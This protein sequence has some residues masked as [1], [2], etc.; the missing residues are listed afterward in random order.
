M[1]SVQTIE[2]AVQLAHSVGARIT[3]LHVET[4]QGSDLYGDAALLRSMS[5][6]QFSEKFKQRTREILAKAESAC[7]L[8]KVPCEGISLTGKSAHEVI[9]QAA[10]DQGCDLIF[11]A[12]HGRRSA[13]GMMIGSET[14]KTLI[15]AK[16]PVLISSIATNSP[17]LSS[18]NTIIQDEHHA[19]GA[20][21]HRLQLL[22]TNA[23][24]NAALPN[25]AAT[26]E[27]IAYLRDFPGKL[28]HPKEETYLFSK[29]SS[30][31]N[32]LDAEIAELRRQHEHD[33]VLI[34][35]LEEAIKELESTPAV[36]VARFATA[37]EAFA[38]ATWKHMS[39]E[40]NL[41]L[42]SARKYFTQA[43]WAE[44]DAAF[45]ANAGKQFGEATE[46][47][48]RSTFKQIVN[49]IEP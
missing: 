48:L 20:V 9:V 3:F 40:E 34:R 23:Q 8:A 16:V 37:A 43:D 45:S 17:A 36:G 22:A 28:H 21:V 35:E 18:A 31:T 30:R 32:E 38:E 10:E 41:I 24:Q 15:N 6:V 19:L 39:M 46:K 4:D 26:R 42:P 33:E 49:S 14:L 25:F 1:L 7:H 29:L 5:P 47:L 44:I 2:N 27:V 11:M 13:I 12:S